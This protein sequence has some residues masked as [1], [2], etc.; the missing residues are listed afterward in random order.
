MCA[1]FLKFVLGTQK[2]GC[3]K[4]GVSSITCTLWVESRLESKESRDF[5]LLFSGDGDHR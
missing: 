5:D 2:D 1:W 4:V 3:R